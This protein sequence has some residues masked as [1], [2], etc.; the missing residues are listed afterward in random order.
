MSRAYPFLANS[1][2]RSNFAH[3]P[4][5]KKLRK[6]GKEHLHGDIT[7]NV[8]EL[9]IA[10]SRQAVAL[11]EDTNKTNAASQPRH[12]RLSC[13][14][15]PIALRATVL[16]MRSSEKRNADDKVAPV[17]VAKLGAA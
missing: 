3:K 5:S 1:R 9:M 10:T 13:R 4:Q 7:A 6:G 15:T 17:S 16:K 14:N 11:Y 12:L 8:S 2:F